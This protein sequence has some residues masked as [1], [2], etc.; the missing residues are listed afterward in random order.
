MKTL[1]N[2][3]LLLTLIF[4]YFQSSALA[5]VGS[6]LTNNDF[7]KM[8]S[9]SKKLIGTNYKRGST[10]PQIGFDCDALI[11]YIY[12]NVTGH[13]LP[14]GTDLLQD[15]SNE[16]SVNELMVGDI[17]GYD[18]KENDGDD[19][20]THV[21]LYLGKINWSTGQYDQNGIETIIHA[22]PDAQN[23]DLANLDINS[24][25]VDYITKDRFFSHAGNK[26]K[27]LRPHGRGKV[28]IGDYQVKKTYRLYYD[29]SYEYQDYGSISNGVKNGDIIK[30]GVDDGGSSIRFMYHDKEVFLRKSA[31]ETIKTDT[32]ITNKFTAVKNNSFINE[33]SDIYIKEISQVY[34]ENFNIVNLLNKG[35]VVKGVIVYKNNKNYIRYFNADEGKILYVDSYN[36]SNSKVQIKVTT[37]T[38]QPNLRRVSDNSIVRYAKINE[39]FSGYI[40]WDKNTFYNKHFVA[41]ISHNNKIEKIRLPLSSIK[42]LDSEFDSFIIDISKLD[43][44]KLYDR[45]SGLVREGK[46]TYL[47]NNG[48]K[49]YGWHL[50]KGKKYYFSPE[51]GGG[52]ITGKRKIGNT[53]YL[54]H[55]DGYVISGWLNENGKHYYFSP[56]HGGGMITGKRKVGKTTYL[57]HNDGY[58]IYGWHLLSGKK[59][60]FS[61][62]F[63]GGM[64]TGLRKV[65]KVTYY[66]DTTY[67]QVIYQK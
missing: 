1:R 23:Q 66:F 41:D 56:E 35:D 64:I 32:L 44:D 59:Y 3:I 5:Q 39:V 47:Y 51:H 25:G 19:H 10:L 37:G 11:Y 6:E 58:K 28:N 61:P 65:G 24:K 20:V 4:F 18:A 60:Y 42:L 17:V 13:K 12:K 21:G 14:I 31:L 16:I 52:M 30:N 38:A 43:R 63:G 7:I 36:T 46:T 22:A 8:R 33:L 27:V 9:L 2:L 67:G 55:N 57:F 45:V 26:L 40:E 34:D 15:Y 54:I 48:I 50:I 53:T 29:N 62:E 49:Q